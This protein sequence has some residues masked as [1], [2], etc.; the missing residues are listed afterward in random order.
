MTEASR[1]TGIRAQ[2][3][4]LRS[5]TTKVLIRGGSDAHYVASGHLVY[6]VA[7]TLRA[8]A[9]DLRHLEVMG[10]PVPVVP[11]LL[12]TG[13]WAA[14]FDVAGSGTL[15]YVPGS[16]VTFQTRRTLVWSV[17]VPPSRSYS[18]S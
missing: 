10:S 15:I 1:D 14:E 16:A 13:T 8:V 2:L 9:F 3:L 7:G 6:G 18:R 11:Q 12:T 5:G 17:W 4:D